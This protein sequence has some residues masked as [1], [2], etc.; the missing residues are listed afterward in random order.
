[1]TNFSG[2]IGNMQSFT[3]TTDATTAQGTVGLGGT[4]AADDAIMWYT[5]TAM[6]HVEFV[7]RSG[8]SCVVC[9]RKIGTSIGTAVTTLNVAGVTEATGAFTKTT[10]SGGNEGARGYNLSTYAANNHTH[11]VTIDQVIRHGHTN[12]TDDTTKM[13]AINESITV[14]CI[15]SL[16]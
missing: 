2:K 16:A 7:S 5:P 12:L 3:F 13:L 10:T 14:I 8:T 11:D 4:P 6:R 15:Y 9:I 1:M